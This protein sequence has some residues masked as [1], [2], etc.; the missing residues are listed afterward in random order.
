MPKPI[1]DLILDLRQDLADP[2]SVRFT[3]AVLARCISKAVFELSRDLGL[4]FTI[5]ASAINPEPSM[6]H[7]ELI[8]LLASINACQVM[9]ASTADGVNF[10][11]GD[12]ES[13][14]TSI[15]KQWAN[16][17]ESYRE[18]YD[19][20]VKRLAPSVSD[21]NILRPGAIGCIYEQGR[22]DDLG[23]VDQDQEKG[24]YP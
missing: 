23:L 24:L 1:S 9:R 11:T 10:K 16:L 6:E 20:A 2:D 8:L 4:V 15:P 17:E 19:A 14:T 22:A 18:K 5:S 12:K 21:T 13:D 7:A 3:D